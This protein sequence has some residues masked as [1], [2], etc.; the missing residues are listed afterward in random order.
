MHL[1]LYLIVTIHF[2]LAFSFTRIYF[3]YFTL[4]YVLLPDC[5]IVWCYFYSSGVCMFTFSTFYTVKDYHDRGCQQRPALQCQLNLLKY[6]TISI[7]MRHISIA[8]CFVVWCLC[9]VWEIILLDHQLDSFLL[10]YM[11]CK[12][13]KIWANVG[14]L[15]ARS[16]SALKTKSVWVFYLNCM[17]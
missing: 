10:L 14:S 15:L 13:K 12:F 1:K 17:Y 11:S 5:Q 7:W 6:I 16:S 3:G 9:Y 2:S 4:R 8:W